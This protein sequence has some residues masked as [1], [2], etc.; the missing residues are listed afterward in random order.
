MSFPFKRKYFL[1]NLK[2]IPDDIRRQQR[3][4]M[5]QDVLPS[6]SEGIHQSFITRFHT[7]VGAGGY[8]ANQKEVLLKELPP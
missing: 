7:L 4:R 3:K 2:D 5:P 1:K 8:S 6:I